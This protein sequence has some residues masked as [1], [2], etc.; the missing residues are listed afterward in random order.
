MLDLDHDYPAYRTASPLSVRS[1]ALSATELT[2]A[3]AVRNAVMVN[4][5]RQRQ[6]KKLWSDTNLEEGVIL[7][8]SKGDFVCQPEELAY[9]P[10]GFFEQVQRL[11]VKV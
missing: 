10:S 9:V 5:L 3:N 6:L 1:D 11:N 8:R 2:S 7:K 4:F